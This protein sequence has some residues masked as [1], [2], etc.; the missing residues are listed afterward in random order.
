MVRSTPKR[1]TP[2]SMTFSTFNP[3]IS[4]QKFSGNGIEN[5]DCKRVDVAAVN[6][7][8]FVKQMDP[9]FYQET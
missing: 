4:S 2:A 3:T 7:P 1:K 5:Q 9:N 6:Q 8:D